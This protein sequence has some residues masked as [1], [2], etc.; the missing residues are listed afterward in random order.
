LLNNS[1]KNY[2]IKKGNCKKL[3]DSEWDEC[4]GKAD[5]EFNLFLSGTLIRITNYRVLRAKIIH[6]SG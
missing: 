3:L 1:I 6:S 4:N 5:V 2:S